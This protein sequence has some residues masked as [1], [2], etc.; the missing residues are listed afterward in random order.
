MA[1]NVHRTKRRMKVSM[2][3]LTKRRMK[4]SKRKVKKKKV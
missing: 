1:K 2:K 3:R 4:V